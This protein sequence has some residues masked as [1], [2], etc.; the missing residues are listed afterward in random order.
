M[1]H[2]REMRE[3]S[4]AYAQLRDPHYDG[5]MDVEHVIEQRRLQH[6]EARAHEEPVHEEIVLP[7]SDTD[8]ADDYAEF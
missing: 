2:K 1:K 7:D 3:I 8:D 6:R 5:D 4:E